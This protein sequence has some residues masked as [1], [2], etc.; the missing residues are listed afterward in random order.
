MADEHLEQMA[1][2]TATWNGIIEDVYAGKVKL[3]DRYECKECFNTGFR[4]ID[5]PQ[6]GHYRGVVR[7]NH[8]RYWYY[9]AEKM[10]NQ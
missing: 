7:C 2:L 9:H 1:S 4:Q 5:D 6:G 3:H 8:C 10:R